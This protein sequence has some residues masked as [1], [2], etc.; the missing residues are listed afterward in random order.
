MELS[1]INK[2]REKEFIGLIVLVAIIA[3]IQFIF[4]KFTLAEMVV[5]FSCGLALGI[6]YY[7]K[8]LKKEIGKRI[9][10]IIFALFVIFWA[11]AVVL[12]PLTKLWLD[13]LLGANTVGTFSKSLFTNT[14]ILMSFVLGYFTIW[15]INKYRQ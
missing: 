11:T 4:F 1:F 12:D 6:I 14:L 9:I 8:I 7:G 5:A 15:I 2:G 10:K 13:A 3:F